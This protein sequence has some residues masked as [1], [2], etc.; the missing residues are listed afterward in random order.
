MLAIKNIN[1]IN[2][3]SDEAYYIDVSVVE[4]FELRK[5]IATLEKRSARA[6]VVISPECFGIAELISEFDYE[7]NILFL[8][9]K[10]PE[11][12]AGDAFSLSSIFSQLSRPKYTKSKL[13]QAIYQYYSVEL[14]ESFYRSQPDRDFDFSTEKNLF[15]LGNFKLLSP[16]I[17]DLDPLRSGHGVY[18]YS[19][20]FS[21]SN[22]LAFYF[23]KVKHWTDILI[24][25]SGFD[26]IF[27][28]TN[29]KIEGNRRK[30][31]ITGWYGTETVGDKAI[32]LEAFNFISKNYTDADITVTSIDLR[33]SWHTR[34][35]L[36]TEHRIIP[37]D[38]AMDLI[39]KNAFTAVFFGGGPIMDSSRLPQI[40]DIFQKSARLGSDT[41]IF[42]CGVGPLR[43][44]ESQAAA[45][46]ILES[47]TFGFFRDQASMTFAVN[48]GA[49]QSKFVVGVDPALN[50]VDRFLGQRECMASSRS[51]VAMLREQTSEY[52]NSAVA[53]NQILYNFFTLYF[54]RLIST[55]GEDVQ[56][57][58]LVPMHSHWRGND[59]RKL[60]QRI[61]QQISHLP[62]PVKSVP[63]QSLDACLSE[64]IGNKMALAMRYHAHIFAIG[65]EVPFISLNYTGARGKID[66]LMTRL[67]LQA[68][69]I[70]VTEVSTSKDNIDDGIWETKPI[71][72]D[73]VRAA[74]RAMLGDLATSYEFLKEHI[75][76]ENSVS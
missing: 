46:V 72:L 53:D 51:L 73:E 8:P 6:I 32:L 23:F 7:D 55:S 66:N 42:G 14:L 11:F 44:Y 54:E 28:S 16:V 3:L 68:A 27:S 48:L 56:D 21:F 59:D 38:V 30:V 1:E 65:L 4:N 70:D 75:R 20:I 31:L 60:N 76:N 61:S 5:L 36:D 35:E 19:E 58:K 9:K 34:F 22:V 63:Y 62:A 69:S 17:A 43:H 24:K 40:A 26:L 37:L 57:I 74:K 12:S 49:D 33:V 64:I 47:S 25:R 52:S 67:G 45:R 39:E 41:V 10:D 71:S 2:K 50:S 13:K 29:S 15:L 18:K